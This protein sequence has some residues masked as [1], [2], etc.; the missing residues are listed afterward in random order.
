MKKFIYNLSRFAMMFAVVAMVA[1]NN[2]PVTN[3]PEPKPEPKPEP[4][5]T[6]EL[7][8][9]ME[10]ELVKVGTSTAELKLTTLN[11]GQYAYSVDEAGA[12]NHPGSPCQGSRRRQPTEG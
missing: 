6:P 9:K 12:N 7:E 8:F 5:P 2:D 10:A 1:C 4:E 3:D 11:I